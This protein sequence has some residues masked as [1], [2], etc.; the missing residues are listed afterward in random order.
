MSV[1]NP[2]LF[3]FSLWLKKMLVHPWVGTALISIFCSHQLKQGPNCG[4]YFLSPAKPYCSSCLPS[5]VASDQMVPITMGA[6]QAVRLLSGCWME[7]P[8][9]A[10]CG[11]HIGLSALKKPSKT[12][13]NIHRVAGSLLQ[14]LKFLFCCI[15]VMSGNE[16]QFS[17]SKLEQKP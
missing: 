12:V 4:K 11:Q 10:A 17:L 7:V 13:Q 5:P 15:G 14:S 8:W 3:F 2:S 16:W 1:K 6:C 9:A